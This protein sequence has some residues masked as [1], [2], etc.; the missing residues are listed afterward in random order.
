[1]ARVALIGDFNSASRNHLATEEALN[2]AAS[3]LGLDIS[4]S[5]IATDAI[6]ADHATSVLDSFD[7]FWIA[8]GSPYLSLAG[9]LAAIRFARETDRPLLGT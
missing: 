4:V 1:M 6:P 2:Q 5:W 9:A 7:G 3:R 8:P